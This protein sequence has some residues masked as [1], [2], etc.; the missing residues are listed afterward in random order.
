MAE[1]SLQSHGRD[2]FT[3]IGT[4]DVDFNEDI[5]DIS[6]SE[7]EISYIIESANEYFNNKI[8]RGDVVSSWSGVRP[9]YMKMVARKAQKVSRD[10]VIR[11]DS[12]VD[13]SALVNVFGGKLT[14]FRQLSED[15]VDLIEINHWS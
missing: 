4:T 6:A 7:S 1:Y 14:T 12:R 2:E 10:Y 3:F 13:D 15:V 9:L 11:E 5:D 8:S